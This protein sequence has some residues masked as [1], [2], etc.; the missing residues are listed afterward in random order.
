MVG[1]SRDMVGHSHDMAD[2]MA[3]DGKSVSSFKRSL[4]HV[5][6]VCCESDARDERACS[7]G[8]SLMSLLTRR[9]CDEFAHQ[10]RV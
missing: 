3:K 8:V 6:R 7:P 5:V 9:E 2:G 4:M 1:H 10:A